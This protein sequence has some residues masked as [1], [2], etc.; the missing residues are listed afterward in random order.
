MNNKIIIDLLTSCACYWRG[1]DQEQ[2]ERK[3]GVIVVCGLFNLILRSHYFC[4]NDS[5][6]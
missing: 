6:G 4:F 5:F 1:C 3:S 2:G